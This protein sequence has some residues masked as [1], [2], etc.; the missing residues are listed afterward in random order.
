MRTA[1]RRKTEKEK[2]KISTWGKKRDSKLF[3]TVEKPCFGNRVI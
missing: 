1:R 2:N 3:G